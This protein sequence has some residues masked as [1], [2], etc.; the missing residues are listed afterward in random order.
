[1][2]S[3]LLKPPLPLLYEEEYAAIRVMME[4]ATHVL[5]WGS[6]FSTLNF[7]HLPTSYTTIEHDKQW[8]DNIA[9]KLADDEK[10]A[11]VVQHYVP[12]SHAGTMQSTKMRGQYFD[13]YVAFVN[14]LGKQFDLVFI[15]GRAR[16]FCVYA[17]IPYLAPNAKVIVHDWIRQRYHVV[18][19]VFDEIDCVEIIDANSK[20]VKHTGI[21][22]LKKA[23]NESIF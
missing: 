18:L 2:Q 20:C 22:A 19:D 13:N 10:F 12:H 6:G 23:Q 1:M 17:V 3:R 9:R 11:N 14:T 5:E 4:H 15:D 16:E 8:F 21:L 7:G